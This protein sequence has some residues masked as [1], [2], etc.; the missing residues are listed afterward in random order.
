MG[1]TTSAAAMSAIRAGVPP[2]Y[3]EKMHQQR[4]S[5]SMIFCRDLL[6]REP[7]RR[8]SARGALGHSY[9]SAALDAKKGPAM[10]DTQ[11]TL[12][13]FEYDALESDDE[14]LESESDDESEC[15]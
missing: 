14:S 4:S 5:D 11:S 2:R 12:D 8:C 10:V 13:P 3:L 1:E 6:Q 7:S 15:P 9:F